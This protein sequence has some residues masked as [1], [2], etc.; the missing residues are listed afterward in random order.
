MDFVR[1]RRRAYLRYMFAICKC[2]LHDLI[3][4]EIPFKFVSKSIVNDNYHGLKTLCPCGFG[5]THGFPYL[6]CEYHDKKFNDIFSND[7]SQRCQERYF[8]PTDSE[9][10]CCNC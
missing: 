9:L 3:A 8:K 2:V 7:V 4:K 10:S 6:I 5:R 1:R